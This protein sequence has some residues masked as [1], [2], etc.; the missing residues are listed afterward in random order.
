MPRQLTTSHDIIPRTIYSH[1]HHIEFH[2]AG[3]PP[4]VYMVSEAREPLTRIVQRLEHQREAG[5][6]PDANG[7]YLITDCAGDCALGAFTSDS[8]VLWEAR[9]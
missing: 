1:N 6:L 3:R 4:K 2:A 7:W 9:S 8:D 5:L